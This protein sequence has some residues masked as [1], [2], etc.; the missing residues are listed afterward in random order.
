MITPND[1]DLATY[2]NR[3]VCFFYMFYWL[4]FIMIMDRLHCQVRM[5]KCER[6][7]GAST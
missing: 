4:F 7:A 6:G 2:L 3:A 5:L 1:T